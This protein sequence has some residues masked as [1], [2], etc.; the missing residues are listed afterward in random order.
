MQKRK[1]IFDCD[2]TMGVHDCD[3]DDGLAL[4]YLLGQG[5]DIC[6]ITTTYGNSD[7]AAVY[8]NTISLLKDLG[9]SDIPVLKGCG[10]S[11]DLQ[12]EAVDFILDTVHAHAGNIAVLGT[13]SLTNLYGAYLRDNQLFAQISEVVL[14]GGITEELIINGRHLQELNFSCDPAA[15][16][17]VLENARNLSVITG[18][19]CLDAFFS[20]P[21]FTGRLRSSERRIGQY[22][23]DKC[24][25]WFENMTSRFEL[26]GFH[27]WD[28]VAAAYLINPELFNKN[29]L[30]IQPDLADL[31]RGMLGSKSA[32]LDVLSGFEHFRQINL[33]VI[34][35]LNQ[36]KD[37]VYSSWL[38]VEI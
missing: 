10:S 6:G 17:C 8:P 27:N 32:S 11:Q 35:E 2:N 33:P 7:I 28:V 25:Y 38:E 1:I 16:A 30:T 4:I 24:S 14:M 19:N 9:R 21:E 26:N 22:I 29:L 5:A 23:Y 34:R 18:N 12:S 15:A 3:V 13:G 37:A 36:F 20:Y 31:A